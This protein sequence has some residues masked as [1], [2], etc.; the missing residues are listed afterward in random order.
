MKDGIKQVG[1]IGL[2][3]MGF[4]I[5]F[6]YAMKGFRTTAY[7]AAPPLQDFDRTG[8]A[9]VLEELKKAH[10]T[11]RE[12]PMPAPKPLTVPAENGETFC[13]NDRTN[14]RLQSYIE[15]NGVYASR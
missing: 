7:D 9:A 14:P 4:H 2:G 10:S 5:A 1:V 6:L 12:E 13:R 11:L 3:N 8:A 15:R